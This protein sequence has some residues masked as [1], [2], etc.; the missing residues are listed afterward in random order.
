MPLNNNFDI[1]NTLISLVNQEHGKMEKWNKNVYFYNM[2]TLQIDYR[3]RVGEHFIK[4]V[5]E[6]LGRKVDY[7]ENGHGDYDIVIDDY[8]IE[9]KTATLDVNDKFQHEGIKEN[10]VEIWLHF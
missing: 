9:I 5:F 8:K 6:N 4:S 7:I 1:K 3:G 10:K 2:K